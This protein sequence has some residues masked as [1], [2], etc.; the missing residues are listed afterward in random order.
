MRRSILLLIF[1]LAGCGQGA[2]VF[3]PTPAPPDLTPIRYT[4]PS[5]AFS[6]RVPPDWA[7]YTQHNANLA[8]AYFT[9]PGAD[10]P[11]V[12]I[13]VINL[14]TPMD[15]L[16]IINTYQQQVR[17]D[18]YREQDRQALGDGSWRLTGLS[19]TPGGLAKQINTFIQQAESFVGVLDVTLSTDPNIYTQTETLI[20]TFRMNPTV[21]LEASPLSA[22]SAATYSDLRVE[23]INA[24]TTSQGVYFITGEIANYSPEP[25]FDVPLR[26]ELQ[27]ADGQGVAEALDTVMGYAIQPG[28]F[29]PFSLR[30]GQGQ[31]PNAIRYMLTLGNYSW[32]PAEIAA[33]RIIDG[34]GMTWSD[35][36]SFTD[37]GVLIIEGT[38]TNTGSDSVRDPLATVTV[39]DAGQNVIAAA[40]IQ[41]MEGT[42]APEESVNFIFRI[43]EVGGTPTNYIVNVQG[44]AE[45]KESN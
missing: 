11:T 30:F 13:A 22:L 2:V 31:P 43:Q 44:L 7:V 23:N 40:F 27:T 21:T 35:S 15:M 4:H 6:V 36:S 39:F 14:N 12:G 29:A 41:V 18:S 45:V 17:R 37:D 24:W 32:N 33:P 8:S 38:I 28:E 25:L 42:L 16:S 20:N 1:L 26:I 3:A 9:P 34:D 10:T 5:G 19:I